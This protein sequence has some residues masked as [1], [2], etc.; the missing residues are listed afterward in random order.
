MPAEVTAGDPSG[1]GA[2]LVP[3]MS[4]IWALNGPPDN[5]DLGWTWAFE[6]REGSQ[7]DGLQHETHA[8]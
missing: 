3:Q 6:F 5:F 8:F 4:A 1:Q 2:H 7:S